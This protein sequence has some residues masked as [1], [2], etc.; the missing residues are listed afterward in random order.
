[1]SEKHLRRKGQGE[2]QRPI[3][4]NKQCINYQRDLLR[5]YIRKDEK[6]KPNGWEC[7]ECKFKQWD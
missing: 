3:C 1:M 2:T 4:N 6:F 7:P 5:S